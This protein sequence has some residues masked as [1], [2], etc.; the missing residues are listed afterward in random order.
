MMGTMAELHESAASRRLRTWQ[1]VA[2]PLDRSSEF[3]R[4]QE[5]LLITA[6]ATILT[7]RTQLWLT[8]YPQLG[9]SGLHIAHLLWGGLF[10]L[11]T[12][13]LLLT[14]LGRPVRHRAAVLGGI[15]FGFF[16][17]ELGKFITSDNN[18]FYRPAAALIYLI[19]LGLFALSHWA[20][21]RD[22]LTQRESLLNAIDLFAEAARHRL[23]A[24]QR[25][26][27]LRL[28]DAADQ[29]DPLVPRL[30]DLLEHVEP[31]P[32][33]PPSRLDRW[34]AAVRGWLARLAA[35]PRFATALTV[36]FGVWAVL[37]LIGTF[38][39][40]LSL[41][42]RLGGAHPGFVGD[43]FD[44]LEL[45]NYA[46]MIASAV[47]AVLVIAGIRR[48]RKGDRLGGLR[49]FDRALLLSILVTQVFNFV[50]S[51][52]GAVFGLAVNLLLLAGVRQL[53]ANAD[54]AGDVAAAP[55][56]SDDAP[57]TATAPAAA[58]AG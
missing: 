4:A 12:I 51:Q 5:T 29:D 33:G 57:G 2:G 40:T 14:F 32:A 26:H 49:D 50:E 48:L 17:D 20:A 22:G 16:I 52:F 7:I 46:S 21:T 41:F 9:G 28:L 55:A 43:S 25:E 24:R 39:L 54:S 35:R 38:E 8:N 34:A 6:V 31:V 37:T 27:A 19:F 13:G 10:M 3:P 11:L 47:A 1:K 53:M 30:R 56:A 42:M 18:Y 58:P 45:H 44:D 15:G 23:D 36:L